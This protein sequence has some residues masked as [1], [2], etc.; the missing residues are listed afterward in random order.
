MGKVF[1]TSDPHFGHEN[2]LNFKDNKGNKVRPFSSVE[3]MNEI[4][5]ENW[6]KVVK[7]GDLVYVLGDITWDRQWFA[8]NWPKFHGRKKLAPGNHDD[9]QW[10]SRGAFFKS[11]QLWYQFKSLEVVL[12]HV[13][14]ALWNEPHV[15]Y[16]YNIHGHTHGND[17]IFN[18][19]YHDKRYFNVSVEKT[20]YAPIELDY[21]IEKIKENAK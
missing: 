19:H 16:K 8:H 2:I 14:I 11:V 20:N 7:P 10:L 15:K 12:S 5:L 21:V 6:N 4:L 3:E 9:I 1:V 18:D 13:P 17:V